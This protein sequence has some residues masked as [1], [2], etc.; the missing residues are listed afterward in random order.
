M[1]RKKWRIV[2]VDPKC[3]WLGVKPEWEKKGNGTVDKPRLVSH[4]D[5]K[6]AVQCYQP[7]P[8]VPGWQ[9]EDLD[10][11]FHD[12]FEEG[13]LVLYVDETVRIAT[14]SNIPSGMARIWTQG[15]AKGIAAW[16]ATQ[17]PSGIPQMLKTESENWAIFKLKA[18]VDRKTVSDFTGDDR[19]VSS[20]LP[21]WYWWYATDALDK[22]QLMR[23]IKP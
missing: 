11:F 3:F 19:L 2:I 22:A 23:P 12:V 16:A 13:N 17:R 6:L 4:F 14:P 15:R 9:N 7:D 5:P 1:A 8:T 18:P 21:K 20:R 10:S